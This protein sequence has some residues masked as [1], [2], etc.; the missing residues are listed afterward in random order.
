LKTK[1]SLQ[2]IEVQDFCRDQH[3]WVFM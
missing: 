1:I 2:K 3:G